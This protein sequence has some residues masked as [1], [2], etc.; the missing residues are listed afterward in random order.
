MNEWGQKL[1][2]RARE[3]LAAIE[4]TPEDRARLKADMIL[5]DILARFYQGK[6]TPDE[7]CKELD[8][9]A[10][11]KE[12]L[13]KE[14]QLKLIE[15]LGLGTASLD[16]KA[17]GRCILLLEGF[18]GKGGM[19]AELKQEINALGELIKRCVS[20]KDQAYSQ[21]RERVRTNPNLRMKRAQT[22]QGEVVV[23]LSEEEAVMNSPEWHQFSAQHDR[24][25]MIQFEHSM[26]RLKELVQG[27]AAK[28]S[29]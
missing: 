29:N 27:K 10:G 5:K 13:A 11:M 26:E 7:L 19:R 21:F 25:C 20:D 28:H 22:P 23:R 17:R 14:A 12:L 2:P 4:I 3:R 8:S 1:S 15:S 18:K 6:I 9:E 24:N 16:F